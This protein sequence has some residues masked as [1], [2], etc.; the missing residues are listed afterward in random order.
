VTN[1][2]EPPERPP[3][4]ED[5]SPKTGK[6]ARPPLR[7]AEPDDRPDILMTPDVHL[8]TDAMCLALQRDADLYQR[9]GDLVH[10]VHHDNARDKR[11]SV[12]TPIL[13]LAPVS[14]LIDRVSGHARCLMRTKNGD[15]KH[16]PPPAA[17]VIAVKERG[18]WSGI[19]HIEGVVEAPTMRPDGSL[20]QIPGFDAETR[21]LYAPNA[22]FAP[23]AE[24]PSQSDATLAYARL[25]DVFADFPYVSPSHQSAAISAI[26]TL[27][28]RPAILGSVPC[29]LLDASS[30]RS[31]K[32]LQLDVIGLVAFGRPMSRTTFPEDEE[33]LESLLASYALE[34][35]RVIP[36][37][38]ITIDFGGGAL[39]KYITATDSVDFRILGQTQKKTVPWR[40]VIFGTGNNVGLKR[41]MSGR[42][43]APRIEP[44]E[45]NPEQ[46]SSFRHGD[47]DE[48]RAYV[49]ERRPE[50]VAAALTI[51][52]AYVVAGRPTTTRAKWGGFDAWA[53]VVADALIWAGAPD[54]LGARRGLL[55]DEDPTRANEGALLVG[56]ERV[57]R[58]Q[59]VTSMTAGTLLGH[60]FPPP[61]ADEPPDGNDELREA[62]ETMTGAKP[63]YPPA[64]SVMSKLLSRLR[65]SPRN[66][67]RLEREGVTHSVARWTVRPE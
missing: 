41:D 9:T 5:A 4:E 39:N 22:D 35:A 28:V 7:I 37:D 53:R 33:R 56:L 17:R 58:E 62:I 23:V 25:A 40:G 13:R 8:V 34:G 55:G 36:F 64:K 60:I 63:G 26:I 43:I 45:E 66:G 42:V 1:S 49:L 2:F 6:R 21:S 48:L 11:H 24:S 31:G 50:L 46:R 3:A 52:R 20:V 51:A 29:Y 18:Q 38:D 10:V 12:G 44:R 14:W 27:L 19:R 61:R 47:A 65:G 57:C 67:R 54:P 30:S 32:S 15:A 16:I 59:S